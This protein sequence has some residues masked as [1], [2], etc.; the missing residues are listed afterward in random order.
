MDSNGVLYK[1]LV[2]AFVGVF[3]VIIVASWK[4]AQIIK[5]KILLRLSGKTE[6]ENMDLDNLVRFV[7]FIVV[8]L[9]GSTPL[10]IIMTFL[11]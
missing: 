9:I 2:G 8:F 10:F 3:L 7:I 5:G 4:Y 6:I 1:A 11:P